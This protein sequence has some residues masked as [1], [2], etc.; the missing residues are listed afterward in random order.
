ML[1]HAYSDTKQ[2]NQWNVRKEKEVNDKIYR[3]Q[4]QE[5]NTG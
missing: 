2:I 4:N 1:A 5:E 3:F